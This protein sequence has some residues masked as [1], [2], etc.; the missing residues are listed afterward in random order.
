M[1]HRPESIR[2]KLK[3]TRRF[4]EVFLKFTRTGLCLD[5]GS[6]RTFITRGLT[7]R[8]GLQITGQEELKF[9]AFGGKEDTQCRL[10]LDNHFAGKY[11]RLS[12][13]VVLNETKFGWTLHG[14]FSNSFN[15]KD[16]INAMHV[17]VCDEGKDD[18][19][20]IEL[21]KF[22]DLETLGIK[23]D[24]VDKKLYDKEMFE[25]FD[26]S[27]NLRIGDMKLNFLENLIISII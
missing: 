1:V 11:K 24:P 23:D 21:Q 8:L 19:T 2:K 9:I 12:P 26:E 22:W 14:Q 15:S 5:T 13:T 4:L 6:S 10:L 3:F 7:R 27:L 20:L 17:S 16:P 18:K 25:Q